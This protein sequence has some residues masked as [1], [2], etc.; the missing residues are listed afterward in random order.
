MIRYLMRK[1]LTIRFNYKY[2]SV[3]YDE[4][5]C[6][7]EE[8]TKHSYSSNHTPRCAKEYALFCYLEEKGL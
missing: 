2:R 3:G 8:M 5:C 6:C 7:G 4:V 1:L